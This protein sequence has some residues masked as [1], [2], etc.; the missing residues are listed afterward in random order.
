M[1]EWEYDEQDFPLSGFRLSKLSEG[2]IKTEEKEDQGRSLAKITLVL[3]VL[4]L[5]VE[6][7]R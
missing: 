5:I 3:E 4:R 6:V 1:P 2:D 7:L